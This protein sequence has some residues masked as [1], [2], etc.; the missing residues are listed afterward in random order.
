MKFKF[1]DT[2]AV[3]VI[4]EQKIKFLNVPWINKTTEKRKK[5]YLEILTQNLLYKYHFILYVKV[6]FY[7]YA[8][9]AVIV[10][11][12]LNTRMWFAWCYFFFFSFLHEYNKKKK[13]IL[14]R[15]RASDLDK[16][17]LFFV[18]FQIIVIELR[19]QICSN[20]YKAPEY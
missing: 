1:K 14:Q 8:A 4:H 18:D 19:S 3:P 9:T 20:F 5:N 11:S 10:H 12:C 7:C 15:K 17:S 16:N 6:F 2:P 13:N